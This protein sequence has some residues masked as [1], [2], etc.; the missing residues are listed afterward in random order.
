LPGYWLREFI[1]KKVLIRGNIGTGKTL[2]TCDLL[3][4]AENQASKGE[5]TVIEMAPS[6]IVKNGTK[7]GGEM[8]IPIMVKQ[9]TVYLKAMRVHA[10]R[11][12]GKGRKEV[13][14]MAIENA[15]LISKLIDVF[16][17][18]PTKFLFVNDL[19]VFLQAGNVDKIFNAIKAT[20][21]FIG[22]A[23][24]GQYFNDDKGSGISMRERKLVEFL[25][26]RMDVII[27]L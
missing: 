3:M 12:D 11:L 26:S 5:I 19:S 20:E 6:K 27:D 14:S 4:Q 21:T 1:G 24:Y 13:E 2:L 25:A 8:Q 17:N 10:P 7:V 22:N 15:K 9:S 23:Y 18:K 16:L